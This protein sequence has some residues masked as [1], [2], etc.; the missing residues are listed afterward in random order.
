MPQMSQVLR[1]RAIGML[2]AGI[3]TGAVT[4]ELH[5]NFSTISHL[6]RCFREFGSTSNRPHNRRL[7]ITTPVQDLHI[8]LDQPPGQLPWLG[9]APQ[10]VGLAP[11]WVDGCTPA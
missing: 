9:L 6:K 3:S 8:V 2:T 5:L 7:H 11:Q 4:R 1:E 10:W